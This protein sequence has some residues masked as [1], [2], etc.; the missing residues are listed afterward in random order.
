MYQLVQQQC[1]LFGIVYNLI[2][3]NSTLFFCISKVL[4]SAHSAYG[5]VVINSLYNICY[6][7]SILGPKCQQMAQ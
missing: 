6:E 1:Q 7:I 4:F 3:A 2:C 5:E